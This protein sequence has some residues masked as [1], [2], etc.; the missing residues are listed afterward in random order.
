[1]KYLRLSRDERQ[2]LMAGSKRCPASWP[3]GWRRCP[4]TRRAVRARTR[5]F[6]PS[7]SAGTWRTWS[8]RASARASGVC[9]TRTIR[10]CRTSTALGSPGSATIVPAR[11]RRGSPPSAA[12]REANLALL[13]SV[14][15][16]QWSRA[17]SQEGVGRVALCDLPSMMAEHDAA[18]RAEIE[19]WSRARSIADALQEPGP[20]EEVR[21]A[22]RRG[23]DLERDLRGVEPR[24]R[25]QEA[26][27]ARQAEAKSE[28]EGQDGQGAR[29][30]PSKAK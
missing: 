6:R 24:D 7:S 9:S 8:A 17:G 3:S 30:E 18:H 4:P 19:A 2:A 10:S 28:V 22:P 21:A 16:E 25:G 14:G 26:S 5:R 23:Q 12:A 13:R 15:A 20:A 1:M 27:R 11:W 29:P